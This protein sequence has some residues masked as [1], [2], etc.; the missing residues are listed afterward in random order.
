MIELLT[1]I[2]LMCQ[3]NA[4]KSSAF[5]VNGLQRDCQKYYV[6]CISDYVKAYANKGRAVEQCILDRR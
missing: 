2:T 5:V 1:A 6:K 4:G 3:I